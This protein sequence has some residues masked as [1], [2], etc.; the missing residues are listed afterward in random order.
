MTFLLLIGAMFSMTKKE[1]GIFETH[2]GP[3]ESDM[4]VYTYFVDGVQMLDPH[5][6]IVVRDGSHIESRLVIPGDKADLYDD[7]AIP[8]KP[9]E[10]CHP[11]CLIELPRHS[12]SRTRSDCRMITNTP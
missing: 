5:N 4:Y 1:N 10:R 3:V 8:E 11:L 9:G 12:R 7:G 6:G 2:I